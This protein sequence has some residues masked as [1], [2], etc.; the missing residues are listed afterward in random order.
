M[1]FEITE[2]VRGD[3]MVV[4]VH[5]D[6]DAV[7]APELTQYIFRLLESGSR[8]LVLDLEPLTFLDSSG[9]RAL[10]ASQKAARAEAASFAMVSTKPATLKVFQITQLDQVF[11]IHPSI[12]AATAS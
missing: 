9:L 12:D 5:G 1:V 4:A 3:H 8:R 6:L 11:E 10:L 7:S 2:S